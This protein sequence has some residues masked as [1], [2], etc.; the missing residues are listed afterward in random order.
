MRFGRCWHFSTG[1]GSHW[2]VS[3]WLKNG[4]RVDGTEASK[5]TLSRFT[6]QTVDGTEELP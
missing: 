2:N 1:Y 4:R 3:D 5:V 6:V